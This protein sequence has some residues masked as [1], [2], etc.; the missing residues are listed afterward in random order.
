MIVW[1]PYSVPLPEGVSKCC[2][3][4]VGAFP[5]THLGPREPRK[6][7]LLSLSSHNGSGGAQAGVWGYQRRK[8]C[9]WFTGCLL[10]SVGPDL[11]WPAW[12]GTHL[13]PLVRK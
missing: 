7:R 3:A 8:Q 5:G 1:R 11:P 10:G 2:V 4:S 12:C 13:R 9:P 6:S